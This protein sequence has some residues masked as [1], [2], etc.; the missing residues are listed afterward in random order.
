MKLHRAVF[1]G[2]AALLFFPL[3]AKA[4]EQGI[5]TGGDRAPYVL[6]PIVPANPNAQV[7]N[8]G[9]IKLGAGGGEN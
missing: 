2:I 7:T 5:Y 9:G 8:L 4:A 1:A 3:A 6:L